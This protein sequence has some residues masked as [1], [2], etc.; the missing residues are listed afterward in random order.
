MLIL[1]WVLN[2]FLG[3]QGGRLFEVGRL[4]Q[5]SNINTATDRPN[6]WAVLQLVSMPLHVNHRLCG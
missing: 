5:Q 6:M 1:G 3:L 2:N 4:F